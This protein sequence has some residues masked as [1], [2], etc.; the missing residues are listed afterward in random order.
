MEASPC[1]RFRA[2]A[3][4]LRAGL[5]SAGLGKT[6]VHHEGTHFAQS[7]AEGRRSRALRGGRRARLRRVPRARPAAARLVRSAGPPRGDRPGGH[8]PGVDQRDPRYLRLV[9]RVHG[10][11]RD[12]LWSA[13]AP[14]S[15]RP[16]S[17]QGG[18]RRPRRRRR[19]RRCGTSPRSWPCSPWSRRGR[20]DGADAGHARRRHGSRRQPLVP[21]AARDP[22]RADGPLRARSTTSTRSSSPRSIRRTPRSS[23][24]SRCSPSTATSSRR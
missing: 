23:T 1:S 12:R 15:S 22:V 5:R 3:L 9:P 16:G 17:R 10:A 6:D 8:R 11:G 20:L 24:R 21:H 2:V 19:D 18:P 7:A 14:A 4:T 13:S